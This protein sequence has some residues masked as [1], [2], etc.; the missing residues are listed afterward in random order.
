MRILL[1]EDDKIIADDIAAALR[2]SGFVVDHAADGEEAWFLGDTEPYDAIVLDLGL[3]RLDGLSVLKRWRAAGQLTPVL[4]LS[5]RGSWMERVDGI[6]AGADDYL[7]KPFQVP[8]L[9]ARLRALIRRAAG[10]AQPVI[11]AGDLVVDTRRMTILN[12]GQPV[13][14]TPLEFRL[15]DYL[16]HNGDRAVSTGELAEHLHGIDGSSDANAIEAMIS[17]LRRKLGPG[18]I[19]TR[20]GFGYVIGKEG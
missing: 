16:V 10:M 2:D 5:A 4:I 8:E 19:E 11:R 6:E 1:V 17:R 14:V 18:V 20:R 15:V 7:P 3:P 12:A 13:K 9:I